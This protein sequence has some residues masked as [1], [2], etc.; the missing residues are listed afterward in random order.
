MTTLDAARPSRRTSA[1]SAR[2]IRVAIY[3]RQSVERTDG[4]E[5]GSIEAQVEAMEAYIKSQ[6]AQGWTALPDPYIDRNISG[7]TTNRPAFQRMLADIEAGRIDIVACYKTDRLNRSLLDFGRLIEFLDAHGVSFVSTTQQFDTSTPMGKL[8]LNDVMSF[9]EFERET[10]R[11]RVRDKTLASK[12]RGLWTG[13]VLPLGYDSV[14][15]KLV[16]NETEAERVRTIYRLYLDSSGYTAV[17]DELERRG[18]TNKAWTTKKGTRAGGKPFSKNS[19]SK[20]LMNPLYLGLVRV[21]GE[22]HEGE[23][24]AIVPRDLWDS[25]QAKLAASRNGAITKPRSPALLA[26]LIRCGRCGHAM[27]RSSA[28][29]DGKTY[30]YYVCVSVAKRGAKACP[31]GRVT[32]TTLDDQVVKHLRGLGQNADVIRATIDAAREQHEA[33]AP[34]LRDELRTAHDEHERLTKERD[35]LLVAVADA[36]APTSVLDRIRTLDADIADL[37]AR[38]DTAQRALHAARDAVVD[39]QAITTALQNFDA[40]YDVLWPQEQQRLVQL[41][42]DRVTYQAPAKTLDIDL[43][44]AGLRV[45]GEELAG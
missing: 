3:A 8:M 16:V 6:A 36:G 15:K 12:R 37:D 5:F 26:G 32:L 28:S 43:S 24:E 11:E 42:I 2:P 19:L 35:R 10:T 30:T 4:G 14:D 40:I 1:T 39:E 45:L 38:T 9:A 27:S 18:W 33:E 17:L 20:L 25:V 34:R 13:G 21:E 22:V 23:H 41:L 44:E 7:A 31:G 29:K